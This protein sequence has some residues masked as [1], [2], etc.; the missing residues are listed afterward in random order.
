MLTLPLDFT[1]TSP[2]IYVSY[3]M[4][5]ASDSCKGIGATYRNTIIP[6][7]NNAELSSLIYHPGDQDW[8]STY[9]T[10]SY[11]LTDLI[12]PIPVSLYD[13]DPR[14][15]YASSTWAYNQFLSYDT[16]NSEWYMTTTYSC[17]QAAAYAPIIAVPPQVTNL[18]P[19]WNDCTAW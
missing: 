18:D 2:T 9:S 5:Y 13:K 12:L 10:I 19:A 8:A 11:N 1:F 6:L 17:P 7:T 14:C 15:A 16:L 3:N 4:L